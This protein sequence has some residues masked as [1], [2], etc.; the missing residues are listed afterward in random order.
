MVDVLRRF[1]VGMEGS[2]AIRKEVR[3]PNM[4]CGN[5]CLD[6]GKELIDGG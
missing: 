2:I 3:I 1:M 4:R 6:Q 5:A